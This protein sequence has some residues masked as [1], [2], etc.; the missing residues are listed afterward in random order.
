[1]RHTFIPQIIYEDDAL[2][3]AAKPAGMLSQGNRSSD[4]DMVSFL[5]NHVKNETGKDDPYIALI[6]RLDRPVG[7]VMVFAKTEKAAADL[8]KQAAGRDMEKTYTAV[9]TGNLP[10]ETGRLKAYLLKDAAGNISSVV[11]E[12]TKGAKRAELEYKV[13]RE[14]RAKDLQRTALPEETPLTL[15]KIRLLT[16]RHHQ[17]RVQTA[18]AGAGVYGDT[19]YNSLFKDIKGEP[20]MLYASDLVFIHPV[21]R[22]KMEFKSE[23][24]FYKWFE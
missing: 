8:S 15:V 20:L 1:M 12:G 18:H 3:A 6:H 2:I 17:I 11:P 10:E 19:K 16:G 13:V 4:P 22:K 9:L 24:P 7:G 21:S 14:C 5:K 23:A